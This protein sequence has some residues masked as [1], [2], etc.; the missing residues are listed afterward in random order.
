MRMGL[1]SAVLLVCVAAQ[2]SA[3]GDGARQLMWDDLIPAALRNADPLAD[4]GPDDRNLVYWVMDSL[5]TLPK[6][7][8]KTEDLFEEVGDALAD[9]KAAGVD[10]EKR[11]AAVTAR[12]TGIAEEL[13][14]QRVRIPGYLLP[15]DPRQGR[16]TDFLLVPWVGAC[17]HTPPPP[18]NQIVF[19]KTATERG[20]TLKA[21]FDPVWVSGV[22]SAKSMAKNL[23]LADGS[24][25][26]DI[27]YA[28]RADTIAPYTE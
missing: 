10:F 15:L 3:A 11:S 16:G 24:A 9:L 21:L 7:G 26:V 6:R 27:G 12:E 14:G 28:L 4:L 22:I 8:P 2:L 19:V 5:A 18:P 23:F 25:D 20:Y 13:N 17:I 1:I